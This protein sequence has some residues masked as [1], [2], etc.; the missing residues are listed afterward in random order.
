MAVRTRV[1]E[2]R[3]CFAKTRRMLVNSIGRTENQNL[4]VELSFQS[5]VFLSRSCQCDCDG[6]GNLG[7]EHIPETAISAQYMEKIA[8]QAPL[9]NSNDDIKDTCLWGKLAKR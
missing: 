2:L 7:R 8:L 4:S 3:E 6:I 9:E 1:E 5:A